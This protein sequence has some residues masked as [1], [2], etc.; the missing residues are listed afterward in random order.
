M[1]WHSPEYSGVPLMFRPDINDEMKLA[2]AYALAE[3]I[4]DNELSQKY[5]SCSIRFKG[6]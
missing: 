4:D 2:A 6:R 5:Y 1:Y 3:L